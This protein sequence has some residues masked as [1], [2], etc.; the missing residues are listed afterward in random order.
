MNA[1]EAIEITRKKLMKLEDYHD[2]MQRLKEFLI[3]NRIFDKV[4]IE[5]TLEDLKAEIDALSI[6]LESA[7][8]LHEELINKECT[9][10]FSTQKVLYLNTDLEES[11]VISNGQSKKIG[12]KE[13]VDE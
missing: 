9:E 11:K 2:R 5:K 8:Y 7:K 13:G 3:N 1:Q 6:V 10:H 12:I 4:E